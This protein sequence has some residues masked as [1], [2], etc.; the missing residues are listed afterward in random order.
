MRSSCK[1]RQYLPAINHARPLLP[2]K[3]TPHRHDTLIRREL[4]AKDHYLQLTEEHFAQ[5]VAPDGALQKALQSGAAPGSN[6][7]QTPH[8]SCR[9]PVVFP[10][11]TKP[12]SNKQTFKHTRQDSNL[13]P[14][15]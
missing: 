14:T 12:Y 5:A 3:H 9:Y 1:G 6:R 10:S 11:F 13:R 15:V 8:A 4:L 7:L 2:L